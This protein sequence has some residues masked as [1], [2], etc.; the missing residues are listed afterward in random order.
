[1]YS[2]QWTSRHEKYFLKV[3][4]RQSMCLCYIEP[5]GREIKTFR[6]TS[7]RKKKL[8]VFLSLQNMRHKHGGMYIK[9]NYL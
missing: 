9:D 7:V 8:L 3:L 4:P 2:V 6:Q 5:N 1:M